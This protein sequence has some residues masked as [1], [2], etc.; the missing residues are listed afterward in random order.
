MA[1]N[2][3]RLPNEDEVNTDS[4]AEYLDTLVADVEEKENDKQKSL[5]EIISLNDEQT[6]DQT[7]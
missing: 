7:I 6:L 4:N 1:D 5:N 2:F 3:S